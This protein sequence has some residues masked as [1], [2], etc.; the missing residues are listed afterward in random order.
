[1]TALLVLATFAVFLLIDYL[2]GKKPAVE[3]VARKAPVAPGLRPAFAGGFEVRSNLSYHPGHTWAL[4][5]SPNFVRVGVD[6]FAAR[7][8][9]KPDEIVVPRRGQWVRQGQKLATIIRNGGRAELVSP[10]EGEVTGL[11]EAVLKDPTL[12]ARDPYGEGWLVTVQAP[13]ARTSFRNLLSGTLAR[14]WMEEAATRLRM[15]ISAAAG[16]TAQDGGLAVE[17]LAEHLTGSTWEKLARE[18]FLT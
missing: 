16:A 5:E 15:R 4:G 17:D 13:D 11:N 12:L 6:D 8:I 1:M 18:F 3:Q 2:H 9:G 7:L 10:I 14:H